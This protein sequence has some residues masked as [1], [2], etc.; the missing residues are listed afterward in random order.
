MRRGSRS[1]PSAGGGLRGG[2]ARPPARAL[3][4]GL[5]AHGQLALPAIGLALW[6]ACLAAGADA[7]QSMRLKVAFQPNRAGARTTIFFGFTVSGTAGQVPSPITRLQLRLPA[8]MG[9]ATTTLGQANCDPAALLRA[10]LAG[11]S[12]NARIGFGDAIAVVPVLEHPVAEKASITA[13]MGPPSS[14]RL[15]VLFYAEGLTPVFA[16]FVFPGVVLEDS[17]PFGERIDTNI[18]LL[19]SWPEGPNVVLTSFSS[20]IGPL[21]L[22]YHRQVGG[23]TIA[24]HPHGVIVPRHCPR[25]GYPFGAQLSF[26]DGTT[27][28]AVAHVPCPRPAP[29]RRRRH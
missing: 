2:T 27:A 28:G 26:E 16:T 18:P 11:C 14:D 8:H 3:A 4:G 15:E 9:I 29:S 23:R 17:Q 1:R 12:T 25:G 10:G 20:T 19:P 5:R 7:A 21:H 6:L 22:T 24:Y 13:L